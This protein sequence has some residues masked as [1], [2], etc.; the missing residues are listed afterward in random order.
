MAF[1][2]ML[3]GFGLAAGIAWFVLRDRDERD[4]RHRMESAMDAKGKAKLS[5]GDT[6]L[7]DPTTDDET[8]KALDA[9]A[10]LPATLFAQA[11]SALESGDAVLMRNTAAALDAAGHGSEAAILRGRALVLQ[12][13]EHNASA[14]A[15][16]PGGMP[17]PSSPY[18]VLL[19]DPR[20]WAERFPQTALA[21]QGLPPNFW[22]AGVLAPYIQY[23]QGGLHDQAKI[24]L[25]GLY[26]IDGQT[27]FVGDP[28]TM[29]G[30]VMIDYAAT[31]PEGWNLKG[32]VP[33]LYLP[34]VDELRMLQAVVRDHPQAQAQHGSAASAELEAV[35]K[36][37]GPIAMEEEEPLMNAA[38]LEPAA[39]LVQGM[40]ALA[41][42]TAPSYL[43]Y[44]PVYAGAVS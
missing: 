4:R 11:K 14:G 6:T 41:G 19:R 8:E 36:G 3:G 15:Y 29:A 12:M 5:K 22:L 16:Y 34:T 28:R 27:Y 9:L 20:D 10:S 43:P 24:L 26:V 1:W 40:P 44:E 33:G 13:L 30:S 21:T 18:D 39:A 25:D 38:Y 17:A 37:M 35:L 42:Y 2:Y 31:L 23:I 7:F 32:V